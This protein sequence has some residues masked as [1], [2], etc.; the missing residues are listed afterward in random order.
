M[1]CEDTT[2][3]ECSLVRHVLIVRQATVVGDSCW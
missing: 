1:R 3:I 2:Q